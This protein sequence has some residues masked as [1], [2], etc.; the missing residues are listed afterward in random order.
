MV[1]STWYNVSISSI[2]VS[3][4]FTIRYRDSSPTADKLQDLWLIDVALI[5]LTNYQLEW[6][7]KVQ[8]VDTVREYYNLTIFGFSSDASESFEIQMWNQSSSS[9]LAPL[10]TDRKSV[11]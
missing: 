7:H 5:E 4:T 11:V 9:W 8:L 6:E 1:A 3:S 10:S 2:V